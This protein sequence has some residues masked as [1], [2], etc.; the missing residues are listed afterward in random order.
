MRHKTRNHAI[1]YGSPPRDNKSLDPHPFAPV[2]SSARFRQSQ[3]SAPWILVFQSAPPHRC[4]CVHGRSRGSTTHSALGTSLF[5][6]TR[7]REPWPE[8]AQVPRSNK[9][10][11]T[12]PVVQIVPARRKSCEQSEYPDIRPGTVHIREGR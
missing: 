11:R 5:R 4:P 7:L 6:R 8:R 2:V 12:H 10:S 9:C 3:T 1:G